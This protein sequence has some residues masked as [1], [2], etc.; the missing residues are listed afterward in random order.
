MSGG[1]SK[2][3][4]VTPGVTAIAVPDPNP[5]SVSRKYSK[6][7]MLL[8]KKAKLP[9]LVAVSQMPAT[10]MFPDE[11]PCGTMAVML[12][13]LADVT[14]GSALEGDLDRAHPVGT[15]P[16]SIPAWRIALFL[17]L[18]VELVPGVELPQGL[19][20]VEREFAVVLV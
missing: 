20:Q 10:V 2:L 8:M 5:G 16:L 11:A 9:A 19:N 14:S 17:A 12:V 18:V 13:E 1:R 7:V 4:I 3:V 15:A 6:P